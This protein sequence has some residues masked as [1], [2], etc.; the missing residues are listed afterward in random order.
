MRRNN[1]RKKTRETINN[2]GLG[3]KD[4]TEDIE[5]AH[6]YPPWSCGGMQ[7]G[8]YP[9]MIECIK[10]EETEENKRKRKEA[11]LKTL[12]ERGHYELEM[13]SDGSVREEKGAG[14]ALVWIKDRT[15]PIIRAETSAG[16]LASSC[17][18]EMWAMIAGLRAIQDNT[19]LD[20]SE[21]LLIC[22][23]SQS[24]IKVL[25]SG[26]LA[27]K[28][29]THDTL[30]RALMAVGARRRVDIQFVAAHC[31]VEHNEMADRAA[32]EACY[33]TR[34]DEHPIGYEEMIPAV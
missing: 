30:W 5:T 1:W 20:G 4:P 27:K 12:A 21:S 2:L 23:D 29:K 16:K 13:W 34:D 9:N 18:A 7:I 8:L 32:E 33:N 28:G 10:R 24:T 15:D 3:F 11:T 31:G 26:P 22:T 17:K 25:E 19:S 6:S 14:A